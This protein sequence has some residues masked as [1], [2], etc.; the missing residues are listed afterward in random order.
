MKEK[1]G[2]GGDSTAKKTKEKSSP[3]VWPRNNDGIDISTCSL[4]EGGI[5]RP[6]QEH[7]NTSL[8]MCTRI[9]FPSRCCRIRF[10]LGF[11]RKEFA[12]LL[13]EMR[14][15]LKLEVSLVKE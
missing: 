7:V 10:L 13:R 9:D 2:W 12:G 8:M 14:F 5:V 3:Q 11:F 4:L 6:R 1:Q 15:V